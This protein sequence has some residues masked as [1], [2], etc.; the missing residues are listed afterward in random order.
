[1]DKKIIKEHFWKTGVNGDVRL[2]TDDLGWPDM[3][4]QEALS[5]YPETIFRHCTLW[6]QTCRKDISYNK[7]LQ[8]LIRFRYD[9]HHRRQQ[10]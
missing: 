5:D 7:L 10:V 1:M 4:K 3:L 8:E 6:P 2:T 9:R